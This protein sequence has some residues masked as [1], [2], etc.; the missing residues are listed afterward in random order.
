MAKVFSNRYWPGGGVKYT[1][2]GIS[3]STPPREKI[4][5]ATACFGHTIIN[6]AYVN[7]PSRLVVPDIQDGGRKNASLRKF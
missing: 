5:M 6:G 2:Q 4:P 1:R 7:I 3:S